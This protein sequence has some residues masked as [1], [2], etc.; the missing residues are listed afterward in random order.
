MEI[1]KAPSGAFLDFHRQEGDYAREVQLSV[2]KVIVAYLIEWKVFCLI[3][4][5]K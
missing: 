5:N 4:S 2:A 3:A 1:K